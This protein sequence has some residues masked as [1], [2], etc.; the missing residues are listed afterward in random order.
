MKIS[1]MNRLISLI[2]KISKFTNKKMKLIYSHQNQQLIIAKTIKSH[3]KI[4]L[5][6]LK[7]DGNKIIDE[8]A[9]TAEVY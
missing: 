5:K 2:M 9:E 3:K 8:E 7:V 1:T 4:C 6:T